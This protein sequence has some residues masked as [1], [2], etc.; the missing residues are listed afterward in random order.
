[1]KSQSVPSNSRFK[2]S[3]G[4]NAVHMVVSVGLFQLIFSAVQHEMPVLDP[5]CVSPD[6][7]SVE[8]RSVLIRRN[9][10]VSERDV[11][12]HAVS[13]RDGDALDRAPEIQ[14][15]NGHPVTVFKHKCTDVASVFRSAE[16]PRKICTHFILTQRI[17]L[18]CKAYSG[19]L[20]RPSRSARCD[21]R[22]G[23]P[24]L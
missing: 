16:F 15:G 2:Q 7:G 5:V 23:R 3:L 10:V 21:S 14:H 13:I 22:T 17:F 4:K 18:F 6:D 8:T 1:M 19:L 24:A 9:V 12:R 20:S 11:C